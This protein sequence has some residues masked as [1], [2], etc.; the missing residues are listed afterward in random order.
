MSEFESPYEANKGRSPAELLR[1]EASKQREKEL[2][3]DQKRQDDEGVPSSFS[4][5]V[6]KKPLHHQASLADLVR[7]ALQHAGRNE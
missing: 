5:G 6:S 1:A 7:S 4:A 3:V 2:A